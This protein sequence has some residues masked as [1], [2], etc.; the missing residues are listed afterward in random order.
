MLIDFNSHILPG[1]DHGCTSRLAMIRQLLDI[2]KAGIGALV[3]ASEF[4]PG[5]VTVDEFLD[6]REEA[7]EHLEDILGESSVVIVPAAE[8]IWRPGLEDLDGLE[9]VCVSGRTLILRVRTGD[10]GDMSS[11]ADSITAL[12]ERLNGCVLISNIEELNDEDT[13]LLLDRGALG[14]LSFTALEKR[15]ERDRWISMIRNRDIVVLGSGIQGERNA[16]RKLGKIRRN[17]PIEF[18][19]LMHNAEKLLGIAL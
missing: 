5:L 16:Y 18:E 11:M 1:M 2:N 9:S 4:D 8:V 15:K 17:M 19:N 10:D 12:C 7:S 6:K 13:A 3:T 14:M